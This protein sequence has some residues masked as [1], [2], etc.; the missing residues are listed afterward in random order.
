MIFIYLMIASVFFFTF[1]NYLRK[2]SNV[3][4]SGTN[5]ICWRNCF[6][7]RINIFL[8]E[9]PASQSLHWNSFF[10]HELILYAYRSVSQ[11]L[12][13]NGVCDIKILWPQQPHKAKV[14]SS[15][16]YYGTI[17]FL[18]H[19]IIFEGLFLGLSRSYRGMYHIFR[20][21][22][23]SWITQFTIISEWNFQ[24]QNTVELAIYLCGR[25]FPSRLLPVDSAWL[26]SNAKTPSWTSNQQSSAPEIIE[27]KRF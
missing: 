6:N 9:K 25:S 10:L 22:N 26:R 24:F 17:Q 13:L 8:L 12:H 21:Q 23:R 14:R 15:K 11:M 3:L 7:V 19:V 5:S 27:E 18:T 1:T 20:I 2:G 4:K 16:H